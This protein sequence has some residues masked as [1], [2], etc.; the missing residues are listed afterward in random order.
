MSLAVSIRYEASERVPD[1]LLSSCRMYFTKYCMLFMHPL[2]SIWW[3]FLHLGVIWRTGATCIL[4]AETFQPKICTS[5]I[6]L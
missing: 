6:M 3:T 4:S 5:A 1:F 2:Y